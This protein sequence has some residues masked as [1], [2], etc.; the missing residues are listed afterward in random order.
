MFCIHCGSDMEQHARF[1]SKCGKEAA[2]AAVTQKAPHDWN[3][4]VNV[5]GWLLIGSAVLTGL[6]AMAIFFA[7]QFIG[8]MPFWEPE[9]PFEI[10]RL[11]GSLSV[12]LGLFVTALATGLG[13][14]GFGLIT[15]KNWARVF[16][17]VMSVF[18][19]FHFPIGTAIAIYAFWVLLS[20]NG[21]Q[22]FQRRAQA[23]SVAW[24]TGRGLRRWR[25]P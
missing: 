12:L 3:M 8:R 14:A 9:F 4:H 18:L 10:A 25:G 11:V 21:R 20:D 13:F 7:G 23:Q 16:A 1:C 17:L 2:P 5:L 24:V 6:L 22:H 19:V 15:Y